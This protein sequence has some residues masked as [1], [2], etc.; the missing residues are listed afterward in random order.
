[1]SPWYKY[2]TSEFLAI[3]AWSLCSGS[4]QIPVPRASVRPLMRPFHSF[5]CSSRH[6]SPSASETP[7]PPCWLGNYFSFC[8]RFS[9]N[10]S[11]KHHPSSPVEIRAKPSPVTLPLHP[12][13]CWTRFL[14]DWLLLALSICSICLRT[15]ITGKRVEEF[16]PAKFLIWMCKHSGCCVACQLI[17]VERIN[18]WMKNWY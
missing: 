13:C 1:M 11:Q 6:V 17:L 5:F 18:E 9:S 2:I 14:Q 3:G 4:L 7:R 10:V 12:S 16:F 8:V 15:Q